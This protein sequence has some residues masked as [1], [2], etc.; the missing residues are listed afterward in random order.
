DASTGARHCNEFV[1]FGAVSTGQYVKTTVGMCPGGLVCVYLNG[2]LQSWTSPAPN[3][4]TGGRWL[5]Q[6]DNVDC[7][8][9]ENCTDSNLALD[10][11]I[12]DD[13]QDGNGAQTW[14]QSSQQI[15]NGSI[16]WNRINKVAV[17]N[18]GGSSWTF[19]WSND[20]TSSA[21]QELSF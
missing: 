21:S 5:Y 1:S 4:G 11:V 2:T 3:M 19:Q 14:D 16:T 17:N 7:L 6:E 9:G 13:T 15:N 12:I 20:G 8:D 18:Y 10:G